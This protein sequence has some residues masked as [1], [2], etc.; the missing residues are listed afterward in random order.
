MLG[1]LLVITCSLVP[2]PCAL[3][4]LQAY[5]VGFFFGDLARWWDGDLD[6]SHSHDLGLNLDNVLDVAT[7]AV[8][9][10][11]VPVNGGACSAGILTVATLEWPQL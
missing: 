8:A 1:L 11:T 7:F 5:V 9:R 2:V 4:L 6:L 10:L 3:P